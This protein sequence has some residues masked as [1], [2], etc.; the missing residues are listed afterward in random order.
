MSNNKPFM[1]P[2]CGCKMTTSRDNHRTKP[3]SFLYSEENLTHGFSGPH[4]DIHYFRCPEPSCGETTIIAEGFGYMN[5]RTFMIYP[6][7]VYKHF[8]EYVPEQ[9][10]QD[11]VEARKILERSPKASATLARRCLQGMIRDFWGIKKG[12][13]VDEID[14][15]ESHVPTA[16][17]QAINSVR[18]LGNIGAHME[19]DVNLIIDIAPDEAEQL[20]KLIELLID[21]WYI[22]RHEEEELYASITRIER[23]KQAQ[24]DPS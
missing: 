16:Q 5:D 13:L 23:E 7:A 4:I 10:R 20:L 14:E 19:K 1:C 21:K 3:S 11:Y 24:R 17:W 12:R 2:F 18:K 15:L 22:S 9:I 8:P 6:D